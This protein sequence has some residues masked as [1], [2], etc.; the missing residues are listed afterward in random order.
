MYV[1]ISMYLLCYKRELLCNYY[2][3]IRV[4]TIACLVPGSEITSKL[5][6]LWC[7]SIFITKF[8][9]I[10]SSLRG[11]VK[12]VVVFGGAH[13]KV[14]D[15]STPKAIVVKLFVGGIFLLSLPWYWK[16]IYQFQ[17][18]NFSNYSC[19]IRSVPII[20]FFFYN[21]AIVFVHKVSLS[22]YLR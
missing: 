16:I 20:L 17:N 5:L 2:V 22:A 8:S 3:C 11:H 10:P 12:K 13:H 9:A 7:M 1:H 6:F 4:Q 21:P 19:K 15:T 14:E 18:L